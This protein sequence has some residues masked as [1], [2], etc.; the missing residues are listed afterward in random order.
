MSEQSEAERLD[1]LVKLLGSAISRRSWH[2]VERAHA[3]LRDYSLP[4]S[5]RAAAAV[6]ESVSVPRDDDAFSRG[7]Y[8]VADALC[9][10]E[11]VNAPDASF[12]LSLAHRAFTD[13]VEAM[14]ETTS[15]GSS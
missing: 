1:R 3:E 8:A 6:R 5:L 13:G 7:V 11:Y 2:D 9:A 14:K 15:K 10:S 12:V 4:A